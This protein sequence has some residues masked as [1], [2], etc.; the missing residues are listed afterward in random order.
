MRSCSTKDHLPPFLSTTKI[1]N[2]CWFAIEFMRLKCF[3]FSIIE[4]SKLIKKC[5]VT[6]YRLTF[7]FFFDFIILIGS[8]L[9]EL[10]C[11]IDF[12]KRTCVKHH[13]S[14]EYIVTKIVRNIPRSNWNVA[15]STQRCYTSLM[16][17]NKAEHARGYNVVGILVFTVIHSCIVRF[18]ESLFFPS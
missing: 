8:Q 13:K 14:I 7:S 3:W 18:K 1:R 2:R 11:M 17:F 9:H 12:R 6:T 5:S 10:S 15:L 4:R 16:G